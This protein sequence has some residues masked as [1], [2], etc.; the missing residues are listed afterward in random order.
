VKVFYFVD[1]H[2][3]KQ[4]SLSEF[5][6][7]EMARQNYVDKIYEERLKEFDGHLMGEEY[8]ANYNRSQVGF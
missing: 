3:D 2:G 4:G 8:Y 1:R 5:K 7:R 6:I